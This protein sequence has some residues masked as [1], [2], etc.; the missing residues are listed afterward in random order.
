MKK[1][2]MAIAAVAAALVL[3]FGVMVGCS[4]NSSKSA[5][6]YTLL[7]E[8]LQDEHFAVAFKL[9]D[10]DLANA[11]NQGIA[12]V[13]K[14]GTVKKLCEKYGIDYAQA[15]CFKAPETAVDTSAFKGQTLKLG[16]DNEFPPMG[17]VGDDGKD[18]GFDLELAKAVCDNLGMTLECTAI[19]W[20]AKDNMLES[21][22]INC[23][24]NGFTAEGREASYTLSTNYMTNTQTVAVKSGSSIKSIADL[25][26]KN[27]V[28][29]SGSAAFELL[30]GDRADLAATF[31]NL[32]SVPSYMDALMQ[33]DSGAADAVIGDSVL[34]QYYIANSK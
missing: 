11:I 2:F 32:A 10:T 23:I 13:D 5:A 29:Q 22:V 17:F 31:G 15:W 27:V 16:F 33:V 18:T 28:T 21:G 20:N 8:T 30:E 24:W 26:G 1:K 25:K 19:D 12:N 14:D 3:C 4:S 6:K 34:L 7:S 9:G